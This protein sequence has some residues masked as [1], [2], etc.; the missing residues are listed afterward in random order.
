M[1]IVVN[2]LLKLATS[3]YDEYHIPYSKDDEENIWFF[4]RDK[5]NMQNDMIVKKIFVILYTQIYNKHL[6]ECK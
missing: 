4:F 1:D 3:M 5:Y 2:H 6:T